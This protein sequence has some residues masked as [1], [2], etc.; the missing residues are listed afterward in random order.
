[1]RFHVCPG[2]F[3][4]LEGGCDVSVQWRDWLVATLSIT[5]IQLS[6]SFLTSC[7]VPDLCAVGTTWFAP[8]PS[9]GMKEHRDKVGSEVHPGARGAACA[10]C[11]G[12]GPACPAWAVPRKGMA[13]LA[14]LGRWPVWVLCSGGGGFTQS[15]RLIFPVQA[16]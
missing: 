14:G 5:R 16:G 3:V 4:S 1:M 15:Q 2:C 13:V 11:C 10:A 9:P 7:L 8:D 12:T 6:V